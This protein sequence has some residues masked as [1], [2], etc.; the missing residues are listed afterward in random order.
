MVARFPHGGAEHPDVTDWLVENAQKMKADPRISQ[1]RPWR[2]D[3]TPI[4]M[5]RNNA[6]ELALKS[7]IDFL[8]MIDSDMALDCYLPSHSIA[9]DWTDPRAK[10]FWD[11]SFNFAYRKRQEGQAV[12]VGAPYCGPPPYENVYVFHWQTLQGD[13]PEGDTSDLTLEQ[14]TRDHAATMQGIQECAALPTGLILIDMKAIEKLSKPWFYYEWDNE[15]ETGKAST[16]DVTFTR[17][18]SLRGIKQYC[19]WDAWAGHWKR[20]LVGKP[21]PITASQ[22]SKAFTDAVLKEYNIDRSAG[23]E[24]CLASNGQ[25][26]SFGQSW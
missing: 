12:V 18:L 8:L 11:T 10:P 25:V 19:N 21:R 4:T 20:K 2:R 14:Y 6:I 22:V 16:E 3:D 17:D 1:V 23:E 15:L 26:Q 5:S 9:P 7:G 13:M 24:L